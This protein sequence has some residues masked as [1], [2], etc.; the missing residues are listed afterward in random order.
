MAVVKKGEGRGDKRDTQMCDKL[1][2]QCSARSVIQ[3]SFPVKLPHQKK[4]HVFKRAYPHNHEC[5]CLSF[6]KSMLGGGG[7]G[8]PSCWSTIVS[9]NVQKGTRK[10]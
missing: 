5:C 4:W 9:L 6:F 10:C 8:V 2:S 1:T 3:A 7:G